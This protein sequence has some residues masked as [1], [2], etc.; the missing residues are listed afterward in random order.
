MKQQ[1]SYGALAPKKLF[2]NFLL[3]WFGIITFAIAIA[4]IFSPNAAKAD[5]YL[6]LANLVKVSAPAEISEFS[7]QTSPTLVEEKC[8]SY[9]SP[10]KETDPHLEQYKMSSSSK[11]T[12]RNRRNAGIGDHSVIEAITA[13]RQCARNVALEQLAKNQIIRSPAL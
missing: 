13:Y 6:P 7:R 3:M 11:I 12:S 5:T 4:M 8:Q 10:M 9:L 2:K 1:I